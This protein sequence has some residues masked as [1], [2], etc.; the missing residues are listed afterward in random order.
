VVSR[1]SGGLEKVQ[2][3][4][5]ECPEVW[6]RSGEGLEKVLRRPRECLGGGGS[7]GKRRSRESIEKRMEARSFAV[8]VHKVS[9]LGCEVSDKVF[10]S[11]ATEH[12]L[13]N[14][15]NCQNPLISCNAQCQC[16]VSVSSAM[17]A[18]MQSAPQ[19]A[20]A[21]AKA[22]HYPWDPQ[23]PVV[24]MALAMASS[25]SALPSVV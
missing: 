25:A 13:Q 5:R 10:I 23:R 21:K 1:R 24:A 18:P 15:N 14:I 4:S 7:T 8:M 6:R 9:G 2:R 16:N 19:R 11:G 20:K 22:P 17:A 12:F 3:R